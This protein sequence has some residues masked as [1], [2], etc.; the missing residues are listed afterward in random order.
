MTNRSLNAE[1]VIVGLGPVG[2]VAANLAG[3]QGFDVLVI[4]RDVDPFALPRAVVFDTE[5]MR[6]FASIGL[7]DRISAITRPLWGSVYLGADGQPIRTFKSQGPA[8]DGAWSP[9]N[10]FYQPHLE[11][12]L[13]E[14]LA[15]YPNVRVLSEHEV[16]T[17]EDRG[18]SASVSAVGPG[19][20]AVEVE[21]RFVL[22]CDGASSA[23]RKHLGVKLNDMGFEERWLVIDVLM[24]GP[25]R[26][27]AL[28]NIPEEVRDGRYSL[29]ICDPAQ[30][31]TVIPGVGE[32]RRWE[33]RLNPAESEAEAVDPALL[34]ARLSTWV[35]PRDVEVIRSAVYRFRALTAKR[36]RVGAIFLL[37]DAAHQTPPFY[38]QGMCHGIRDAAQLIWKLRMTADRVAP[39][40]LL[41]TY[42]VEREPQVREV[43][44][45]AVEAG[46]AVCITD[47]ERARR[48]DAEFRA[49]E[50][51]RD[52]SVAMS[53]IVP[54]MRAGVIDPRSGGGRIPEFQLL[55]KD[56]ERIGLDSLLNGRFTLITLGGGPPAQLR[57]RADH[58][59]GWRTLNGQ[60]IA[61]AGSAE[62]DSEHNVY[63]ADGRFAAWMEHLG[64]V[65]VIVRP[66]R[67]IYGAAADP[68]DLSRLTAGLMEALGVTGDATATLERASS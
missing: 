33:Y 11:T 1:V 17:A 32:H 62:Q 37:G 61:V 8:Y 42:Q 41:D 68:S 58:E 51:A 29:M 5:I 67:Y 25:M 9:T 47:P 27:P 4:D 19:G 16:L 65:A 63:D 64:A 2:A 23:V 49:A 7:A 60:I 31:A 53:D 52:R 39:D 30:P 59:A 36:W 22:G 48:R 35:D 3:A 10:L 66:D 44:A 24:K 43:I 45:A 20:E 55:G 56:G 15:R 21:A 14:G 46:A 6:V 26:W 12:T 38:G 54:P 40:A 28:Y 57:L 18:G 13:R 50:K 34:Q